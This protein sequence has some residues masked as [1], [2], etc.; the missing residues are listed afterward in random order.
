M[1]AT[2]RPLTWT[3]LGYRVAEPTE[4]MA[5]VFGGALAYGIRR[6]KDGRYAVTVGAVH[7]DARETFDEA[8]AYC[9]A[10]RLRRFLAELSL[11]T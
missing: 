3:P 4:W 5:T 1:R 9:E 2:L 6:M 8:A 7:H 10:D 11:L